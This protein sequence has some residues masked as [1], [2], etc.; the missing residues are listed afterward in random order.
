MGVEMDRLRSALERATV[1]AARLEGENAIL[2]ERLA[3]MD[4]RQTEALTAIGRRLAAALQGQRA[5]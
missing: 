1:L 4:S 2:R 3:K 5:A